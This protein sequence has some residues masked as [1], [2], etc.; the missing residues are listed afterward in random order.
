MAEKALNE[1][2]YKVY[3]YRWVV[4][5]V[6][7]FIAVMIQVMWATFFTITTDAWKYYGYTDA[8]KGESAIS[9]LSII[10][11]VGMIILSVPSMAAFE[12]FG[13]KKSVGF[14]AV[15]MGIC[16]VLRGI[17]GASYPMLIVMT[18]GFSIAQPFILNAP[19]LVAGRWFP[20][21]ERAT[22]NSGGLL[23]NYVGMSIAFLLSPILLEKGIEIKAIM[24]IYGIAAAFSAVLFLIF[25]REA[26]PT[27]PCEEELAVRVDFKE[28]FVTAWKKKNFLFCVLIFFIML[29]IFNAFFTLIEPIMTDMSGGA[30]DSTQSGIIGVAILLVGVVGSVVISLFSDKDKL[31]RRLP[32]LVGANIIGTIGFALFIF[33]NGFGGMMAA[34]LIYGFFTIGSAPVLITLAAEEAYPTSEGTSEGLMMWMGNIGGVIFL[35]ITSLMGNNHLAMLIMMAVLSALVVICMAVMKETKLQKMKQ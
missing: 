27:P 30:I 5:A 16:G 14:G 18:I 12:K 1:R 29:G 28:G 9:L 10:F 22:A 20:E 25:A 35:G 7:L 6:Y 21:D 34:G 19:G 13:F 26:P 23:A 17:F 33:M 8:V 2:T 31:H 15:V 3:G 4:L 11:M 32:Y 24:L